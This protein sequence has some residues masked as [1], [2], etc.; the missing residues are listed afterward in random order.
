ML[1]IQ[2][3]KFRGFQ[4]KLSTWQYFPSQGSKTSNPAHT[5]QLDRL[6]QTIVWNTTGIPEQPDNLHINAFCLDADCKKNSNQLVSFSASKYDVS[7]AWVAT[8]K[9]HLACSKAS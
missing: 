1:G 3:P 9:C 8:G 5:G 2:Y 7:A 4:Q 6:A